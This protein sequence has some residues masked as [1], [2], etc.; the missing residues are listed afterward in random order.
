MWG[1]CLDVLIHNGKLYQR[2]IEYEKLLDQSKA[3]IVQPVSDITISIDAIKPIDQPPVFVYEEL[4]S[5]VGHPDVIGRVTDIIWH[6]KNMDYNYYISVNGRKKSKRY[7]SQD[8][9]KLN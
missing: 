9:Q 7:Y 1:I 8:L 6:F 3:H 5:P 2:A 4:V